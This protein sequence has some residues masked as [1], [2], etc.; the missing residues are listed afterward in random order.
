MRRCVRGA[1]ADV[2]HEQT[3]A[4]LK[5]LKAGRVD[6]ARKALVTAGFDFLVRGDDLGR[7]ACVALVEMLREDRADEVEHHLIS[8]LSAYGFR[9]AN[10]AREAASAP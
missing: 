3:V 8:A 4:A 5:A 1:M 7:K 10:R 2:A 9:R 6:D